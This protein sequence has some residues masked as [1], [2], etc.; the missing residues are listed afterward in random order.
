MW[1]Y[2]PKYIHL[3]S[4]S[5]KN[6]KLGTKLILRQR[7]YLM[8]EYANYVIVMF[9]NI[10]E[11]IRNEKKNHR[12]IRGV[13]TK[14]TNIS[15]ANYPRVQNLELTNALTRAGGPNSS[16]RRA[17]D[18]QVADSILTQGAVLSP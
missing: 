9:I 7:F 3:S 18:C 4:N 17:S 13:P 12:K 6:T 10:N 1:V 5:S 15:V 8:V 14:I 2:L 11:N 16:V